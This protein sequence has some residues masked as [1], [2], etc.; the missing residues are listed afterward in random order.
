M[1]RATSVA[2]PRK[3]IAF[4]ARGTHFVSQGADIEVFCKAGNTRAGGAGD[5]GSMHTC[6]STVYNSVTVCL[7]HVSRLK[8]INF[9][10]KMEKY[11]EYHL[12]C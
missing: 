1:S 8:P 6:S 2:C 12:F 9:S 11:V 10:G 4:F 5:E 7:F 3:I